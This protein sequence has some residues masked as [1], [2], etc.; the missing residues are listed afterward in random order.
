MTFFFPSA[1]LFLQLNLFFLVD[2]ITRY[3]FCVNNVVFSCFN[4][5]VFLLKENLMETSYTDLEGAA[6]QDPKISDS[7]AD[8]LFWAVLCIYLHFEYQCF[9]LFF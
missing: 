6:Y 2:A 7:F 3:F 8:P 4:L 1:V 9:C 5:L